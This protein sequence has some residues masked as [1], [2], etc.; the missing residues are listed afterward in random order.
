MQPRA[1]RQ[2]KAK[3]TPAAG[4]DGGPPHGGRSTPRHAGTSACTPGAPFAS[5]ADSSG[6]ARSG[7]SKRTAMGCARDALAACTP[8]RTSS[9]VASDESPPSLHTSSCSQRRR[10]ECT[11]RSWC[12]AAVRTTGDAA[13]SKTHG[14]RSDVTV[15][16]SDCSASYAIGRL[17][18]VKYRRSSTAAADGERLEGATA[19]EAQR[20]QHVADAGDAVHGN[21]CEVRC[22]RRRGASRNHRSSEDVAIRM[23]NRRM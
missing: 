11:A 13:Y 19:S 6:Q 21:V 2:S 5:S 20:G 8:R 16:G 4:V 1:Q 9:R 22:R 15:V 23:R 7:P 18:V 17:G 14:S 3:Q 10:G 12:T